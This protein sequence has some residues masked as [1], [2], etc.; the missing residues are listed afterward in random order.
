MLALSGASGLVGRYLCAELLANGIPFKLLGRT[1]FDFEPLN[2]VPFCFY[3]LTLPP[4]DSLRSFLQDVDVL[5]NLAAILPNPLS[6]HLDYYLSNSVAPKLLFDLCA[7]L[8]VSKFIYLSSANI[9]R[10]V[11]GLASANSHYSLTLRQPS[12]LSSKIAGELLLLNSSAATD[13]YIVRPSSIYGYGIRS[14]LFRHLYD[15]L[16]QSSSVTLSHRGLWSADFVY[17]GDVAKCIAGLLDNVEPGVF[18][19]GSG[20]VTTTHAVAQSLVSLIGVGEDLITLDTSLDDPASFGSLPAISCDHA[21]LLL[22]RQPLSVT[23]GLNH[24]ISTYGKL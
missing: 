6:C 2:S 5:I 18:N 14:G 22:G 24:A 1:S 23:E 17:A 20:S 13:L 9:L 8:G 19:I 11:G 16:S 15:S 3:D 21:L 10:P 12:Y 4:P 7:D